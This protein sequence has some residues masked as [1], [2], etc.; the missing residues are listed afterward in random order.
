MLFAGFLIENKLKSATVKTSLLAIKGV[1]LENRIK[2]SQDQFLLAS[3]TR[4]CK[5]R[6]NQVVARLPIS[7]ELL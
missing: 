3:L 2:F 5:M 4:A 6:N 1:L 7:R